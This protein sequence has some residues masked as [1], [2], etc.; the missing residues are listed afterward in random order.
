[1]NL[2][3]WD[4][5]LHHRHAISGGPPC[6]QGVVTFQTAPSLECVVLTGKK[7]EGLGDS[8]PR[9]LLLILTLARFSKEAFFAFAKNAPRAAF[10]GVVSAFWK[11]LFVSCTQH[12]GKLRT[13]KWVRFKDLLDRRAL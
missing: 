7:R 6:G 11:R 4:G 1:M 8:S 12:C 5:K 2:D 3:E 10:A 13:P 9:V